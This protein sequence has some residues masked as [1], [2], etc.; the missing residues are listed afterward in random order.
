MKTHQK[1]FPLIW[2]KNSEAQKMK[3]TN[4]ILGLL[5]VTTS[6][7][8]QKGLRN[9]PGSPT[10]PHFENQRTKL[11]L[12]KGKNKK[13]LNS[14]SRR[15]RLQSLFYILYIYNSP[16]RVW[17]KNI[18]MKIKSSPNSSMDFSLQDFMLHSV[19][20]Y[21][22]T[23]SSGKILKEVRAAGWKY[24]KMDVEGQVLP[25]GVHQ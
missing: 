25:C 14:L 24:K 12:L 22:E 8:S 1:M 15:P 7:T 5:I 6:R 3:K 23:D 17:T 21:S 19:K 2:L 13:I 10:T 4:N 9:A 16:D 20:H 18:L 11:K